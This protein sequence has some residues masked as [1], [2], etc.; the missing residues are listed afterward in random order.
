MGRLRLA[1]VGRK[2]GLRPVAR[3]HH[4][5]KLD[6]S[7]VSHVDSSSSMSTT[8][9]GQIC[10]GLSL[11]F[12]RGTLRTIPCRVDLPHPRVIKIF[13]E[14][15]P[16]GYGF[17]LV[18][19]GF[20]RYNSHTADQPPFSLLSSTGVMDNWVPGVLEYEGFD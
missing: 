18:V 11:E 10:P 8:G 16:T 3:S 4:S 13:L 19:R 20:G 12:P 5:T 9:C 15:E 6:D 14:R 1:V 17:S 2:S 7:R